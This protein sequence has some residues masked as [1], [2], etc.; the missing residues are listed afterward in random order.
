MRSRRKPH[1][2][3]AFTRRKRSVR[4][5]STELLED[6]VLL[7]SELEPNNVPADATRF[8]TDNDTLEGNVSSAGDVDFFVANFNRGDTFEIRTPNINNT[9]FANAPVP[10]VTILDSSGEVKAV[11]RDQR[12]LRF[13]V[14]YTGEFF[15]RFDNDTVVGP[16]ADEYAME[17]FVTP[18][19]DS[20]VEVEPNDDTASATDTEGRA[21]VSGDLSSSNAQD[22]YQF[23]GSIGET[24]QV[25]FSDA[26][27]R[28]PTVRLYSPG[29]ELR[30]TNL[31]GS[32]ISH[33]L[34]ETG[35]W[36]VELRG[37]NA[38]GPVSGGYIARI[39]TVTGLQESGVNIDF[40]N[41]TP[42]D[43]ESDAW[44][45]GELSSVGEPRVFS[46]EIEDLDVPQFTWNNG[47]FMSLQN[48]EMAVYNDAGQFLQGS[49]DGT[50][51]RRS[52]DQPNYVGKYFLVLSASS[53]AGLGPFAVRS[54]LSQ[55]F[56]YQR[57]T[58]L[59]FLDFTEQDTHLGFDWVA[60]FQSPEKI[61]LARA[62][63]ESRYDIFDIDVTEELPD[64]DEGEYV[65]QG[66]GDFGDFGAGG[67][68]GGT[69][70]DRRPNGDGITGNDGLDWSTLATG[71]PAPTL[72]HEAG[73]ATGVAHAR[74]PL[75]LMAYTSSAEW[76]PVG[77]Y[78]PF[79]GTD[80]HNASP[81][82]VNLRDYFDWVLTPGIQV[83][84]AEDN[85][86]PGTAQNLDPFINS[87]ALGYVDG[88]DVATGTNPG[89]VRLAKLNADDFLD[90]VHTDVDADQIVVRFGNGDGTFGNATTY[91]AG[92]ED[93]WWAKSLALDDFDGDGDV[94]VAHSNHDSANVV[95]FFNNG[96]G[97]LSA[98]TTYATGAG[99]FAIESADFS[100]DGT[101]DLVLSGDGFVQ[102]MINDGT[103][104]F[105]PATDFGLTTTA[106]DVHPVD[107]NR[108][109]QNDIVT[110]N[111]DGTVTV[112]MNNGFGFDVTTFTVAGD[113]LYTVTAGDFDG[114]GIE[115]V[116][117]AGAENLIYVLEGDDL[118]GLTVASA[119][120]TNNEPWEIDAIDMGL[121]GLPD[122]VASSIDEPT[123]IFPSGG[124]LN[125][126]ASFEIGKAGQGN[127]SQD[128]GDL[129]GDGFPDVINSNDFADR[130]HVTL[131]NQLEDPDNDRAVVYG[132]LEDRADVDI[133]S[134]SATAD[135]SWIF[136][137]DSAEYQYGLDSRLTLWDSAGNVLA[138]SYD[139]LD[140]DTG[141]D[142]VDP[143]LEYKFASK[144]RYFVSVHSEY[145]S[146]GSYRLKALPSLLRDDEGPRIMY[147]TPQ[148]GTTIDSTRQLV[149]F[150]NDQIDPATLD[151]IEVVGANTGVQS[152]TAVFD[153]MEQVVIWT[154]D[155][156]LEVDSYSVTIDQ[157]MSD[158]AGNLLDGETDGVPAFPEVSG[159]DAPGGNY[160]SEF[161]VDSVDSSPATVSVTEVFRHFYNRHRFRLQATD[162]L[163]IMSVQNA[164][165]T[166]IGEGLDGTIGTA[167]DVEMPLDAL[168]RTY[169][170][171]N[172][173]MLYTLG[174]ADP[175][176]YLIVAQV[177]DAAGFP[178]SI[179]ESIT[180][181][182]E[183][184]HNG[185]SVTGMTPMA[186]GTAY[187]F[188]NRVEVRFSGA[189]DVSTLTPDNVRVVYSPTG[190]FGDGTAEEVADA[191]IEWD[192]TTNTAA[193]VTVD[194]LPNGYYRLALDSGPGGLTNAAGHEL[195]GEFLDSYIPGT[196]VPNIWQNAPSGDGRPGG[197]YSA[198]FTVAVPVVEL[199]SPIVSIVEDAGPAAFEIVLTR[200]NSDLRDTVTVTLTSSDETE[201]VLP[202][203]VTFPAEA[204][205]VTIPVSVIDDFVVDGTITV[206]I[207]ATAT[208]FLSDEV[209]I[210]VEDN[211]AAG[212]IVTEVDGTV[213]LE[214]GTP[215]TFSV[216][217]TAEPFEDVVLVVSGSDTTEATVLP[218]TLTFSPA[219]WN[220]PQVV[221]VTGEDDPT[222]DGDVLSNVS[223]TVDDGQSDD[224]FD[225]VADANVVVTTIDDDIAAFDVAVSG[226]IVVEESGTTATFTVSLPVQPLT[227]VVFSVSSLDLS[228]VTA[229]PVNLT[230]T[231]ANWADSQQV[232]VTGVDDVLVDG[233]VLTDVVVA[234]V[235][236]ES[237]DAFDSLPNQAVVVT[238]TDDEEAAFVISETLG[239]TVVTEGGSFDSFVVVLPVQP[240]GDVVFEIVSTD[241][242]ETLASPITLT[243]TNAN[244]NRGQ[245]VF[246]QG[247]DDVLL[248]GDKRTDVVV[249]VLTSESD[250]AFDGLDDQAVVVTT[251]D[252][253]EAGYDV[254]PPT[255]FTLAEDGS[256]TEIFSVVLPVQPSGNV[257]FR[258]ESVDGT[259]LAATPALLTFTPLNWDTHQ[260]VTV[261]GVDDGAVDGDQVSNVVLK[262]VDDETDDAFDDLGDTTFIFTT[263]DD[264]VAGFIVTE[265]QGAI[266]VAESGL[267]G[268]FTI[269]LSAMPVDDV[270]FTVTSSD[271][272]EAIA[273]PTVL[274][275]T[276]LNWDV[277][278]SVSVNGVSDFVVD[279]TQ[280]V[281]LLVEVFASQ[282]QDAFDGL[283]SETVSVLVTDDQVAGFV[284]DQTEGTTI[285]SE[286]GETD[287]F[288]VG[289]VDRP[290]TNVVFQVVSS[291]S[292]ETTVSDSTLTF[293]PANW[294]ET[295]T[296]TVSAMDDP[297]VDGDQISRVVVRVLDSES[298]DEFF[299]LPDQT[300]FVTTIDD[301]VAAFEVVELGGETVV[302]ED[303]VL[304][305][306]FLVSL[307]VR[308]LTEVV[309]AVANADGTEISVSP[310]A[311]TFSPDN[312]NVQQSVDIVAVDE[313]VADG[314]RST[315]IVLS[316][317]DSQSD[318]A[319]DGL[320]SQTVVVSVLD[321]DDAAFSVGSA[322]LIVGEDGSTA[323]FDVVL[324][325]EPVT[326]VIL[327]VISSDPTETET[328]V[329]LLTFSPGNWSTPQA[330]TVSGVDDEIVDGDVQSDLMVR[331]WDAESDDAFDNLPDQAVSVT[332]TDND[333]P[334]L[335]VVE[336]N[337]FTQSGESGRT[338]E[339][340]VA[341]AVQPAGTVTVSVDFVS[342][343]IAVSHESLVFTAANWDVPQAVTVSSIDDG[344]M[345]GSQFVTLTFSVDAANSSPLY[346]AA[347]PVDVEM[348]SVDNDSPVFHDYETLF[349][350]G[351]DDADVIHVEQAGDTVT[352]DLNGVEF[353]IDTDAFTRVRLRSFKGADLVHAETL[354]MPLHASLAK[355]HDEFHGGM[356]VDRVN[357]GGGD[358]LVFGY[359]GNDR[360]STGNG[361]DTIYGGEG[362]DRI[363]SGNGSDSVLG[364]AGNDDIV[365]LGGRD[366]ISG[367][368]GNDLITGD[369]KRDTLFGDAGHDSLFGGAGEDSLKGG[370]G[371]DLLV[372]GNLDDTLRGDDG[373]DFLVG[374][375]GIDDLSS[376]SG[377][378]ILVAGES[379]LEPNELF[380][381]MTEWVSTRSYDERVANI[382]DTEDRTPDREN[383][384]FLIGAGRAR[385]RTVLDDGVVDEL[386]GGNGSDLFFAAV[387]DDLLADR[388]LTEWLYE[389]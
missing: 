279:G 43:F 149:F 48:R 120:E 139:A 191:T 113:R 95:V 306:S 240:V 175:G 375:K 26:P 243:F 222:V 203:S 173:I 361:E 73:H 308:P 194:P 336:T 200:W 150:V 146:Q 370:S 4:K 256:N 351:T 169:H 317:V 275:F 285:V 33:V 77:S 117:A 196:T 356:G 316:V 91:A 121:D 143:W 176:D 385:A 221:T 126:G 75:N 137:I 1:S 347:A 132:E 334:G 34:D 10:A 282:S 172:Q 284:V 305:D 97:V 277:K 99:A 179:S 289:L 350:N 15:V 373:R 327:E 114:D 55:V 338:D 133:Y 372:G 69:F 63:F 129:N 310:S 47:E 178:V 354:M 142:S 28:S 165:F 180:I 93:V 201:L 225:D 21:H 311:L 50:I 283:A 304:T 162:E 232:T 342:S 273:S 187:D 376:G 252:D 259:E 318:D 14:P 138:R 96:A 65:G 92:G 215:D 348:L 383:T 192:A 382:V 66:I 242:T 61:P 210:D 281:G 106:N 269:E 76:F 380:S 296:V 367:G 158:L 189:I 287:S 363:R 68:G 183:V 292:S 213:V 101:A 46:F 219:D 78:F 58:P 174:V 30:A 260:V 3:S 13:T 302:S 353:A 314:D 148:P 90:V 42:W 371:H 83:F 374:G 294:S 341:L 167:D 241:E 360:L 355:G 307:P 112:L 251:T 224:G 263:T 53:E 8:T 205:E 181:T 71:S 153:P 152:G 188:T 233:D 94:D 20:T 89:A 156:M 54:S 265:P 207:T 131:S 72:M 198:E 229:S 18:V 230:F 299:T 124:D 41:A 309:L 37:D 359:A 238:T 326:P 339:I 36:F 23:S 303:G 104:T 27:H 147:A 365:G 228:E 136:D 384:A 32:G 315:D 161:V 45:I 239:Q 51:N 322:N 98:P 248:D 182:P 16:I 357:G 186:G 209:L 74:H 212:L 127:T 335:T 81:Q 166:L 325:V 123:L 255:G 35:D 301:D 379:T 261:V 111:E 144:G 145:S 236:S 135:Q 214:D 24:A 39:D 244:W 290:A 64:P 82:I 378:D 293:T 270:V 319:F 343:E 38:A 119:V 388:D 254:E 7:T 197:D 151:N 116:A 206:A 249:K 247:V 352:V 25:L 204:M 67:L 102:V 184:R 340:H 369:Q 227:D 387:G 211:D 168:Y 266:T 220:Q 208:G 57:D 170:E 154:A 257:V 312:W 107:L 62:I 333:T 103:G 11:S 288:T 125:F 331:I 216:S 253:D 193:V 298:D 245:S 297:T 115:D 386:S 195:D 9:T 368:D 109:T 272:G 160:T 85:D 12:R 40:E 56:S 377:D 234:I 22:Y 268:T 171:N 49:F 52:S 258:V 235:A 278:Q 6:R 19:G 217:L 140:R 164:E 59:Y 110:A 199:S 128:V 271:V 86:T 79:S 223:I 264:E 280:S 118:G 190:D 88:P 346:H 267:P 134:I 2:F 155:S 157:R 231:P 44:A 130:L 323:T 185:L 177:T 313:M 141:V 159:D 330:I 345:D 250:N 324:A 29:G 362:N 291:D 332:T 5:I 320:L 329:G 295:Q 84:E 274:V 286:S 262:V 80:Q 364:E 226:P 300:V 202:S 122:I 218:T 381:I 337:G 237:D 87:M 358:D 163:D 276:P 31:D 60:P 70:G 105:L 328:S 100:G 349:I 17:T 366:W 389:L 246:V 321:D 344:L 108:D